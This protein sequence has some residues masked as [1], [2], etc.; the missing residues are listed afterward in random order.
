M[1]RFIERVFGRKRK[2]PI[3]RKLYFQPT[4]EGLEER[5]LTTGAP[6]LPAP[7]CEPNWNGPVPGNGKQVVI[8][9]SLVKGDFHFDVSLP[10]YLGHERSYGHDSTA[11]GLHPVHNH[12]ILASFSGL[13]GPNSEQVIR[14]ANGLARLGYGEEEVA[15]L[16]NV[17]HINQ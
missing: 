15:R 4:I 13:F 11:T 7:Y 16:L 9:D 1:R 3:V 10:S 8:D 14:S 12:A 2:R 17:S 5:Q 6:M